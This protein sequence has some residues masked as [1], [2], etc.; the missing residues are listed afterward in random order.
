MLSLAQL[1]P[2]HSRVLSFI[3]KQKMKRGKN[4]QT[5][6]IIGENWRTKEKREKKFAGGIG[7]QEYKG[8]TQATNEGEWRRSRGQK[9]RSLAAS[10]PS[11]KTGW[12]FVAWLGQGEE[13]QRRRVGSVGVGVGG[14]YSWRQR[15]MCSNS[16]WTLNVS[17]PPPGYLSCLGHVATFFPCIARIGH[18]CSNS[19]IFR[20]ERPIG[21]FL[22][23]IVLLFI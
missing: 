14:L 11:C 6:T 12:K 19:S 8:R 13:G 7:H 22:N 15:Q 1:L 17:L 20:E 3:L 18:L 21:I 10:F 5:P 4:F 16:A 2:S 23:R 9:S